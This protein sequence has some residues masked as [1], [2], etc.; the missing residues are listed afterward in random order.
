MYAEFY[1]SGTGEINDHEQQK[2]K[3][4]LESA[5]SFIMQSC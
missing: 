1:V 4:L 2:N 3:V 5:K